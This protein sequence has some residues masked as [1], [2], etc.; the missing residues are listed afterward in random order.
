MAQLRGGTGP[1]EIESGRYVGIPAEQKICKLCRGA[2]ED[3]VPFR[4]VYPTLVL[5]CIPLLQTID[6]ITRGF[7]DGQKLIKI[8]PAANQ[9]LQ[10][11]DF[12]L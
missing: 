5:P 1:L 9:G 11:G 10:S 6:S 2:V 3:E 7:K 4:I 8:I 12:P